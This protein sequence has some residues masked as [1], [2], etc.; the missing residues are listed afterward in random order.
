M[1]DS[2]G[3]GEAKEWIA[4]RQAGDAL[5]AVAGTVTKAAESLWQARERL[6]RNN[7]AGV[8]DPR[9]DTILHPDVLAYLRSVRF[10]GMR[11]RFTGPRKRVKACL[12]PN[13][14]KNLGQVYSQLWKDVRKHRALVVDR[15]HPGLETMH[16]LFTL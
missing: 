16:R 9:L 10:A 1:V 8:D 14:K 7:L 12:H 3:D 13:A 2:L 15:D 11:A 6:G 4:V 5:L